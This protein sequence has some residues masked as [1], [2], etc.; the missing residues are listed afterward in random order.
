MTRDKETTLLVWDLPLRVFHWLLAG[1][2]LL[3][4]L[5]QELG[6]KWMDW[7]LASGYAVLTLLLFR[8]AWG[9]A[10]PAHARFAGFLTGPRATA[11]YLADWLAGR[12][13][14]WPGHPPLGGWFA[15]LMIASALTQAATGLFNS[16]DVLAEGPWHHAAPPSVTGPM[17]W[18]HEHNFYLLAGLAGIHVAAILAYRLR[19]GIGLTWPMVTGRKRPW[20][21]DARG[22]AGSRTGLALLLL[23]VCAA[24]VWALVAAAPRPDPEFLF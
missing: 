7:H 5:T 4:W 21:P 13:G 16:D 20:G 8:I 24:M 18:I 9:F 3:S 14:A 1:L 23:A 19:F 17:S 12:P 6:G 15:L 10:G 2:L 22:I 11:R